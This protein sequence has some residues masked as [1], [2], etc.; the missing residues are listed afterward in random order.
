MASQVGIY[1]GSFDPPHLGH[2]ETVK[3]ALQNGM[4][5]VTIVYSDEN[6]F[7]P[8]R[9]N[10]KIRKELLERM[11][12]G[13][14]NVVISAKSYK[15]VLSDLQSD[16]TIAKIH[17]IIGS[18]LLD[19]PVRPIKLPTK[20]AYFIIP[21]ID[22][23]VEKGLSTWNN[24]PA[25]IGCRE[26]L[27]QQHN[28][29]SKLRSLLIERDFQAAQLGLHAKVFDQI[30]RQNVYL[31]TDNEY[32]DRAMLRDV[33][34]IVQDEIVTKKLVPLEKYPLSFH[35][36]NDIGISGLSGDVVCFVKDVHG[37]VRLVVKIFRGDD[38]KS[39][40]E[41]ELAGYETLSQLNLKFVKTPKLFFSHQKGDFA[42]IGMSFATGKSLADLMQSSPEAIRLCARAN[43][44]LHQAQRSSTSA[45]N[46]DQI[47]IYEQAITN[48]INRLKTIPTPFL[49]GNVITKLTTRWSQIHR[50]FIAN[51]GLQSFTHGDPNHSNWIVD[52]NSNCVTYIDLSLFKRSISSQK[53]P[54]GF[55]IS[56]LEES[57]L[58]FRIAA[59]RM[60]GF[61]DD[62]IREMQNTY[63]TEYMAHAPADITTPEAKQYF[64]SYWTLRVIGSIIKKL[65]G[66]SSTEAVSKYQTQLINSINSF[67]SQ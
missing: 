10:N 29:S 38:Y 48:V 35:L 14:Q 49:A 22:Y 47:A 43:L 20:L 45:V 50:S 11:F 54:C 64:A 15:A 41:S 65:I 6:Q 53:K 12:A 30:R 59:K 16:P 63:K 9:T 1:R 57:L 19:K 13:M 4:T 7:K 31:L 36:G 58:A 21:R 40:Y 56:E 25:Q 17:Q 51:P 37:Q 26:Q 34:K 46:A 24:L 5:S 39:N 33:K 32:R 42:F 28:S 8:F 18:D 23:P 55:A 67:I 52:L 2:F 66:S 61:T 44:E 3:H 27:I 62:K 60:G